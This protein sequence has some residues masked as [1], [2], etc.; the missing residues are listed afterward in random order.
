MQRILTGLCAMGLL[1]AGVAQ[2]RECVG[3]NFPDQLQADG[4][5]L[6]LNGL[7][8]GKATLLKVK[9]YV[10]ALYLPKP[11]TDAKA[12]MS[13]NSPYAVVLQFVRNVDAKDI[14]KGWRESMEHNGLDRQ[15]VW[16]D[17]LATL[18]AWMSD[19]KVGQRVQFD[20]R[21]GVGV[22][23]MVSGTVKGTISGDDVGAGLLSIWLGVP[24]N[25]EIKA[26]L[27]GGACD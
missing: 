20:F 18:N 26:G 16:Q 15:P 4:S 5:N 1:A 23:V 22:R 27:L 9:V 17:R 6:A 14:A 19:M 12:I 2:S 11:S 21:P 3:V 24:P 10:A 13:N 25:P 7:G 8:M